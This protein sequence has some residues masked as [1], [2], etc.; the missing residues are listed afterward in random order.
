[1]KKNYPLSQ[2]FNGRKKLMK[3]QIKAT[4]ISILA[5][6]LF[7]LTQAQINLL[8]NSIYFRNYN[9]AGNTTTHYGDLCIDGGSSGTSW[10][11]LYCN[12]VTNYGSESVYGSLEVYGSLAVYDTK[13][14]IQPHPTDTTKVIKYIAIE[15]GEALTVARGTANTVSG[16]AIIELPEHFKLVISN[17]APITVILTPENAPVTLYTKEKSDS[18]I[19]VGM[20]DSDIREFGDVPFAFQVTGVRDGFEDEEVIVDIN[21][22]NAKENISAKRAAYNA[23]VEKLAAKMKSATKNSKK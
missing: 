16:K 6:S 1:V 20:K 17:D 13:N 14:F 2:K 7:F 18:I 4:V 22:V 10:G 19:I 12:K 21:K 15:S 11:W 3:T 5:G 9:N 23:K 8:S